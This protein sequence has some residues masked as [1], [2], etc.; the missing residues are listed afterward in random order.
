MT[1]TIDNQQLVAYKRLPDWTAQTVPA[2]LT[3]KHNT[4]AGT[5]A[6]LTILE[7]QL[8]FY[9]LDEEGQTL[10]EM[11]FDTSSQTPFVQPQSWHRIENL[12]D[13]LR[14]YLTF[15]CQEKDYFAKKYDLTA[16]HSEVVNAVN[17]VPV[18][19]TLDLGSGRGRNSLFLSRLGHQ[20]TAVDVN[21]QNLVALEDMAQAEDLDIA[22][23]WYDINEAAITE[24]YDFILSTVVL[25]FLNRQAIPAI[26][27]NMQE[28]TKL[29]GYNLIVCAMDTAKHPCPMPFPF[30]F[31][32]GELK[33]YYRDWEL[34]KYNEDLGQLHRLDEHGN[35]LQL[36]F[37]TLLAKKI[38]S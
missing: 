6:K 25:M 21:G 19:K 31:K 27:T 17:Y 1:E 26:I 3:Q 23:D 2:S 33:Q 34:I 13:D 8:T 11:V 10:E 5:W 20:V 32:E 36:Q 38:K 18:G 9:A 24:D 37:A 22:I 4:K 14:F 16:T 12:S 15:Y 7:G 28:K 30:T 35:R 29:G